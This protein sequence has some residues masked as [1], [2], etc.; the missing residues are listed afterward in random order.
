MLLL[1][2]RFNRHYSAEEEQH[3][4]S[5]FRSNYELI[6]SHN[7]LAEQGLKSYELGIN[8]FTDLT[9]AEFRNIFNG[10]RGN[11][12]S[13]SEKVHTNTDVNDL[14]DSID[15]TTKGVVTPVKNQLQ[16]GSCWAFSTVASIES[17]HALKTGNLVS[18]SEQQLVDCSFAQG[19]LGCDGGLMDNGFRYVI[20]NH[21]LD[22][23]SSYPYKAADGKC[24]FNPKTVGATISSYVDVQK[25]SED[26]LQNAVGTIGPV[27]VAIDASQPSFQ[28]YAKGVYDE[29]NCSA[30]YLDHGVTAVGY[31]KLNGVDYWKVKNSW[32]ADW[33]EEGYILM[34]RNKQNQCG[35]ATQASYPVV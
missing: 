31:G 2:E 23:E 18:L 5:V 21:G 22:T 14:P 13:I 7:L 15:W 4:L 28:M 29:P 27:S 3:R 33:G 19:D 32:G 25:D 1:K 16:C 34:S 12:R 26:A 24:H 6:V 11:L 10:F 9:N 35:I 8:N 20:Q 17:A 30:V